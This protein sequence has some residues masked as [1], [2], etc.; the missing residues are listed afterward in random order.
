[1]SASTQSRLPEPVLGTAVA[2]IKE[3][4]LLSVVAGGLGLF[5]FS[6]LVLVPFGKDVLGAIIAVIGFNVALIGVIGYV[7]YHVLDRMV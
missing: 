5:L 4:L 7:L 1:M 2:R 6:A 3:S